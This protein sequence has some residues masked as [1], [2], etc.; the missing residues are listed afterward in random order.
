MA[1]RGNVNAAITQ[2]QKAGSFDPLNG[3]LHASQ[4]QLYSRLYANQ[5]EGQASRDKWHKMAAHH[6]RLAESKS[7]RNPRV[8]SQLIGVY[9]SLVTTGKPS[10]WLR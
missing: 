8:L 9:A 2:L 6:A 3:E 4:A 10:A 1:Q 5:Y 7:P